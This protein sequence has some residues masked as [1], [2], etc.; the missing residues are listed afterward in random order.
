MINPPMKTGVP[1]RKLIEEFEGLIL[2]AYDD[3]NDRIVKPGEHI[4]GT[5]TIGYGHTTAAGLP[6]VYVGMTITA[7][8]ADQILSSDL[9]AVE[10]DVNLHVNVPLNPNQFDSIVSFDFNTGSLDRSNV[11]HSINAK[12]FAAVRADLG[13]WAYSKGRLLAGLVRRRKAE[14]DLF[15]TPVAAP[16]HS[17]AALAPFPAQKVTS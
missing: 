10:A 6:K 13:M 1:G 8:Q 15:D 5:L 11:L 7:E 14:A 3:F 16:P 2:G 17:Q 12:Q 9:A 4:E